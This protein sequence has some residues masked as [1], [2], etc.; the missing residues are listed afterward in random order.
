MVLFSLVLMGTVLETF[1]VGLVVPALAF[2]TRGSS[3]PSPRLAAWLEW[4]GNPSAN[5]L[6][7]LVLLMLLGVYAVK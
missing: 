1:S 3:Q 4:L 7:L 5:Q 6:T 2:M